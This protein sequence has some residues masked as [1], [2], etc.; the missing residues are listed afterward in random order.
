[1]KLKKRIGD[2]LIEVGLIDQA[3]LETALDLQK[4]SGKRLGKIFIELNYITEESM[5]EVLEFQLGIPHVDL[6]MITVDPEVAALIPEAMAK[7]HSVIPIRREGAKLILAMADPT[8]IFAIDDVQMSSSLQ[9]DVV[10]ASDTEVE[11]AIN[12]VYGV[13]ETVQKA[14][15]QLQQTAE[16]I[17]AME[18]GNVAESDAPIIN[19]ANSLLQQAAKDGAS[20]IHIEPQERDLRIRFRVD[21][22][23]RDVLTL[24]KRF[25]AALISRF[26]L[27]SEMDISERRL[28][29]DGR[30][31]FR[32]AGRDIDIRVSTLPTI[33]GEKVVGRLLDQGSA[34]IGTSKLGFSAPNIAKFNEMSKKSYGIILVTGP[35]GSG[36]STTLY[37]ALSEYNNV[38]KNIITVEDPVEY[39]LP[40]INQVNINPKAGLD[41]AQTLRAI[42]RQDPNIIMVGEIRDLE[43]AEIA[44][45]A[46]L[47]GHLVFSTLHT[48]DAAST[49]TRLVDMGIEAYLVASSL[50]GVTSQRLVRKI[51]VPCKESYMLEPNTPEHI[52]MNLPATESIQLFRGRGCPVCNHSGYQ[53][54]TGIH[55][56]LILTTR[57]RELIMQGASAD[58]IAQAAKAEGM[59]TMQQDG[60]AKAI[61]GTTTISEVM[62][63]AYGMH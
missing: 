13:R 60:I 44:I 23:L 56:V 10:I 26:K 46:A 50:L 61:N 15:N 41:F 9:V 43:T 28:P 39:R 32:F 33:Y 54:R 24:P 25:H 62:R 59:I 2:L 16:Q 3:Q 63:V 30:V 42:L 14:I 31:K 7:R 57:I 4:K 5:L 21:G 37:S 35:T 48:N 52:F 55:E 6:N 1:M 17:A 58:V 45:R 49:V 12:R 47:T 8:N 34:P 29:Q 27:M 22:I 36:K 18:E 40:G 53:G 11:R 51:C 19:I 38:A 20:D